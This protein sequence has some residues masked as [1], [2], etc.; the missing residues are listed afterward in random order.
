M[1]T[2]K[3]ITVG[4]K[5]FTENIILAHL[6]SEIIESHTDIS[7]IRKINL[8]GSAIIW[9]A[10]HTNEIQI[11]PEYRGTI[12]LDYYQLPVT[13]QHENNEPLS[14]SLKNDRLTYDFFS[15]SITSSFWPC[16]PKLHHNISCELFQIL[17][18]TQI[19]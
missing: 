1:K 19:N 8:G 2:K 14:A 16:G 15:D 11:Y 3:T 5:N 13:S 7:V 4:S 17:Q 12:L 18:D 9:K 10:I 6:I